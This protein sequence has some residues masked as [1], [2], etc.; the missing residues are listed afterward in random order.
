MKVKMNRWIACVCVLAACL[1]SKALP[2]LP[3]FVM[4]ITD[5]QGVYHSNPYGAQE[6][7]TPH[8]QAMADE[9]L[10]FTSAYV[11]SPSCAPSR[12]AL[13]TG[14]MPY[15]NGI[16]GNHENIRKDGVEPLLPI[17]ADLGY[18]IVWYG[19]VGHGNA[20]YTRFPYITKFP[21]EKGR[22]RVALYD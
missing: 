19:K 1:L 7:R 10:R 18:E 8:M 17:L 3:N 4:F 9:G 11:A 20:W 16:V 5:D 21:M 6:M 12:A 22:R 14:L 15:N 13:M 2:A